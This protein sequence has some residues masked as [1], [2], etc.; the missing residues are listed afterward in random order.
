LPAT[1]EL[2]V[3]HGFAAQGDTK[4]YLRLGLAF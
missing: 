1:A 2:T 4:V 3:A